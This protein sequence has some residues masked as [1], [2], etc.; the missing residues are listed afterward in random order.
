MKSTEVAVRDH[1]LQLPCSGF[2]YR[3]SAYFQTLLTVL[4]KKQFL[5][6]EAYSE[7][8]QASQMKRFAK[9][10]S[11]YYLNTWK[12][13]CLLVL[14]TYVKSSQFPQPC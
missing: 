2:L 12:E 13:E 1:I 3:C 8:C 7:I 9:V 5:Q 14:H 6:A 10:G 11:S 4:K